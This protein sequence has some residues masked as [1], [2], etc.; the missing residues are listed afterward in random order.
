MGSTR[1][2]PQIRMVVWLHRLG[3][4]DK[5]FHCE[6]LMRSIFFLQMP[7]D[8]FDVKPTRLTGRTDIEPSDEG[9]VA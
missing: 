4:P 1:V 8:A 6:S 7:I 2:L 3:S 9:L 5:E